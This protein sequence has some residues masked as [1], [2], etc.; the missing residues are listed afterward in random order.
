MCSKC[1]GNMD[2]DNLTEDVMSTITDN[3]VNNDDDGCSSMGAASDISKPYRTVIDIP[4]SSI[5]FYKLY[6]RYKNL[7]CNIVYYTGLPR[8]HLNFMLQ[9]SN[10]Q[11]F[12]LNKAPVDR[13]TTR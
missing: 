10:N 11:F 1:L 7:C 12:P 2:Y 3:I 13:C 5:I 9:K 8:S 4:V 6:L